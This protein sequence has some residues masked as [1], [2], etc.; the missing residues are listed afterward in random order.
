M[1]LD[2]FVKAAFITGVLVLVSLV[3]GNYVEGTA[4]SKLNNDL[5]RVSED[6]EAVLIM[7]SFAGENDTRI[8]SMIESQADSMNGK[9]Y[10]LRSELE[11]QKSTSILADYDS[12]RRAYFVANARLLSLTKQY[13]RQCGGKD[14]V[15]LFFYTSEKECPDCYAQ[16]RIIDD[17]RS[18]CRN[19]KV[20]SFP[21]DVDMTIIKSFMA[22]YNVTGSPS[23]VIDTP[24]RD[25]V[26]G[27]VTGADEMMEYL[28]CGSG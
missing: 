14:D 23:V 13:G 1:N 6:N 24:K 8:C 12:L 4:Y 2:I 17:V 11:A 26:L 19:V 27:N 5:L 15:M 28:D 3:V 20:F 7:Q 18:R 9:I 22:Y 21:V 25:V 10:S 16:G